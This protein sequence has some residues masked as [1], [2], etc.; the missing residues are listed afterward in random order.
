VCD[1]C[2]NKQCN[3]SRCL[4]AR[5][6]KEWAKL[7]APLIMSYVAGEDCVASR[8]ENLKLGAVHCDMVVQS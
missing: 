2:G 7:K 1:N 6:G 5:E 8:L 4:L 3:I